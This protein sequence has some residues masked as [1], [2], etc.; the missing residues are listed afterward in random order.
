[1][2]IFFLL[3]FVVL[4]NGIVF[5]GPANPADNKS[6]GQ[7]VAADPWKN[8]VFTIE[9]LKKYNGK[10]GMPAY[11]AIEGIVYDLSKVKP[12]SG[13]YHM[14][15]HNAGEDLTDAFMNKAPRSIHG[16][17]RKKLPKVGVLA[18]APDKM[19]APVAA[20]TSASVYASSQTAFKEIKI[21]PKKIGT[22]AVCPVMKEKFK[23]T[24]NTT[25]IKYKNKTYYFCCPA[26]PPEFKANPEKYIGKKT[27]IEK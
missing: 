12:W 14:R 1:M 9:E 10:N 7:S 16:N 2:R 13:G 17:V 4:T 11:V 21:S 5:A 18:A 27:G 22:N 25:A 20:V 8:N 19:K 23:I 26:C 15:M 6:A 3:L 24:K